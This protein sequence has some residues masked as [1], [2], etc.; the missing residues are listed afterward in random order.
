MA[1]SADFFRVGSGYA[2]LPLAVA[3]RIALSLLLSSHEKEKMPSPRHKLIHNPIPTSRTHNVAIM[4]S[5]QTNT[6]L[7]AEQDIGMGK[8]KRVSAGTV[9]ILHQITNTNKI[10]KQMNEVVSG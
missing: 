3:R 5:Q 6:I 10:L 9:S 8:Y 2:R 1:Q 4:H 7:K